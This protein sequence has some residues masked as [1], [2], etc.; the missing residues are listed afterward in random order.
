L[1]KKIADPDLAV[2]LKGRSFVITS[3]S[4]VGA[5]ALVIE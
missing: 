5:L 2:E 3:S 4:A 1:L